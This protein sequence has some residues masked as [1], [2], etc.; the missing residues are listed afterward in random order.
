MTLIPCD[1]CRRP[2]DEEEA[3]YWLG[4]SQFV[5]G[6]ARVM[7]GHRECLR[8]AGDEWYATEAE[9]ERADRIFRSR[10]KRP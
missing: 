3:A 4:P 6:P 1:I 8:D 10:L 2:V 9:I 7:N 5:F